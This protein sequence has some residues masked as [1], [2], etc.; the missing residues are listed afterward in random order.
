MAK[1]SMVV[2]ALTLCLSVF[3]FLSLDK[4]LAWFSK[5]SEV[6][7]DGM[8]IKVQSIEPVNVTATYY[9]ATEVAEDGKITFDLNTE[10]DA[11]L[12]GYNLLEKQTRYLLM[13]LTA[14]ESFQL[15]ISTSTT[16]LLDRKTPLLGGTGEGKEYNTDYSN[17]LSNVLFFEKVTPD[18]KGVVTLTDRQSFWQQSGSTYTFNGREI[19][20]YTPISESGKYTLYLVIGYDE[21]LMARL[22]SENIGNENISLGVTFVKDC[23]FTISLGGA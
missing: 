14:D 22:F 20:P 10:Q 4:G 19:S 11:V 21:E 9:Y 3:A 13:K 15:H 17:W 2:T 5:N 6:Q 16:T 12:P 18:E 1:I 8:E 23:N 7:A